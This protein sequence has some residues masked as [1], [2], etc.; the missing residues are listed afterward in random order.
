MI[1]EDYIIGWIKRF[2]QLLAQIVGM[3]RQEKYQAAMQAIEGALQTLLD[4]GPDSIITLSEGQILARLTVGGPTQL[5]QTK[6]IMLAAILEQLAL[7]L[8]AQ[9]RASE[10]R[11]CRIKALHIMLGIT[12]NEEPAPLPEYAPKV[13]VLAAALKGETLP[14][15]TY[16]ALLHFFEHIGDYAKAED[17]LYMLRDAQKDETL[18]E[19]VGVAFYERLLAQSDASLITGNLPRAE[20]ESGLAQLRA[21]RTVKPG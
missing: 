2:V 15:R 11:D 12:L 5:V 14:P 10:S 17:A 18:T 19:E 21:T 6:C 8:A 13:E 1:R 9:N 3:V 16:G 7:A 4:L 20:V